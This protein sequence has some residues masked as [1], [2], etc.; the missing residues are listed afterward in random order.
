[1]GFFL[2]CYEW[3]YAHMRHYLAQLYI[4]VISPNA[5]LCFLI[6]GAL[7]AFL[8]AS[9]AR[10]KRNL[11]IFHTLVLTVSV[12]IAGYFGSVLMYIIETGIESNIFGIG[13]SSFGGILFAPLLLLPV[14]L[15]LKKPYST[16][17][18][19]A[20]PMGAALLGVM[21]LHCLYAGCCY[22]RILYTNGA[23]KIVRFPSQLVESLFLFALLFCILILMHSGKC[24]GKLF[25]LTLLLYALTRFPLNLLRETTPFIWI[26][27]AGNVWS[28]VSAAI[29][30]I[31][32]NIIKHRRD[33]APPV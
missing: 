28:L 27:P 12:L 4:R 6:L 13:L 17:M 7:L 24:T 9:V 18:D 21:K 11:N 2:V 15:L 32:L 33:Y 26:L 31:W 30:V 1:M 14:S 25:P 8:C 5:R 19:F 20:A 16:V 22:G 10:K 3:F 23:G 29:A